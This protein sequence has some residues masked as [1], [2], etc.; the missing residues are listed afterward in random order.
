MANKWQKGR[1]YPQ[2]KEK[3]IGDN[4]N[5]ITYRSSWELKM[6]EMCDQ[7][8]NVVYWASES[9]SIKYKH[10]FTGQTKSYIP[11]FFIMYVDARGKKYSELIEIKP[12]EQCD[13]KFAKSQRDK[14]AVVVN[15]AKWE[16]AYI[17][18]KKRRIRFRIITEKD[19]F[20]NTK[21]SKGIK[22]N[23]PKKR[24]R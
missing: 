10:P 21:Y 15:R 7:H 3:Y 14:E 11:D 22:K 24:R 12:M 18:C 23:R 4:L 5:K 1:F 8:P 17:Y 2:N 19:I 16:A 20:R 13:L 6:C 9:L